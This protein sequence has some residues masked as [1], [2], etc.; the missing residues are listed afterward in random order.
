[1]SDFGFFATNYSDEGNKKVVMYNQCDKNEKTIWNS[2]NDAP[3][4]R[5]ISSAAGQKKENN[6]RDDTVSHN[7]S[8]KFRQQDEKNNR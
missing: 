1:M 3:R 8:I 7:L 2:S 6:A 5:G 4:S